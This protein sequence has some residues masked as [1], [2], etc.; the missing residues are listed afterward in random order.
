MRSFASAR[1]FAKAP[2]AAGRAFGEVP[3]SQVVRAWSA[4]EAAP[5]GAASM[6][7]AS[8]ALILQSRA[9]RVLAA[10]HP[11][12]KPVPKPILQQEEDAAPLDAPFRRMARIAG[13]VF[14]DRA[15]RAEGAALAASVSPAPPHPRA[16]APGPLAEANGQARPAAA[17]FDI[18]GAPAGHGARRPRPPAPSRAAGSFKARVRPPG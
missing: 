8:V 18:G 14:T 11:E 12:G 6:P 3:V 1:S 16:L 5:K 9:G 4:A 2:G 17:P 13:R 15:A 10:L 7:S